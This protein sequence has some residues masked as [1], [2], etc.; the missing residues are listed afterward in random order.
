MNDTLLNKVYQFKYLAIIIDHE[1]NWI[2]HI[3][4]YAKNKIAK[5][6]GIMFK[7]RRF[8]NLACFSNLYHT[9]VHPYLIYCINGLVAQWGERS[10]LERTVRGS[11]HG[12]GLTRH[13]NRV[14]LIRMFI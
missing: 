1:L 5:G 8:I 10:T 14:L 4:T 2:Q 6:I 3:I 11:N 13:M 9:Y 7:A 12:S